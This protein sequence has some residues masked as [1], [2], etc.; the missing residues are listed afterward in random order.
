M[1]LTR[2]RLLGQTTAIA[3]CLPGAVL[4][5]DAADPMLLGRIELEGTG[6]GPVAGQTNPATQA[7]SKT[8]TP[9]TEIPQ[10]VTVIGSERIA[11]Q[12]AAK[13]DEILG[14]TAGVAPQPY[15]YDSDTNWVVIRGFPASATGVFQDGLAH[16]SYG[17]GGFY[18][19][20]FTLERV[21]V[22]KGPAS[23]LYGGANPGGLLN[24]VSKMPTGTDDGMAELGVDE[25]G[26]VW[27]GA[28]Q[29]GV[30]AGGLRWRLVSKLART[31]GYG[32]FDDGVHGVIA[33]SLSFTL[34][35]GTDVTLMASYTHID[36]DHVG[37]AWLPYYGTVEDIG[38]GRIDRDFNSGEPALDWYRRDQLLLSSIV[39]H[40]FDN[41]LT[42]TNTSRLS[43]SDVDE[44]QVYGF[45]YAGYSPTP[46]DPDNTLA[47]IF[48]QHQTETLSFLNDTRVETVANF[49]G[50]EH[51]LLAGVDY[52]WF[53]MD[54]VQASVAWPDAATGISVTNPVYGAPQPDPT[55]Y[56]DQRITQ[57]Q[58]GLYVQDQIRWGQGW[59][60]TLNGRFDVV[61]LEATGTPAYSST[62]HEF[63]WR[64]GIAREL[65]R[66]VTPYLSYATFFNPQIGTSSV[67]ALYPETGQQVEAGVKW[68]PE[69]MNALFTLAAFEIRRE[70]VV[71]GPFN[72][73]TQLG[74]VRSRGVEL[75][76]QAE[77][78][79]RLRLLGQVTAMDVEITED[80][81]T[82]IVGN[83][84]YA[85]I[86]RQ[87][88]LQ[89]AYDLPQVEGLTV[90]GGIRYLGRSWADN[91]NTLRVPDATLF[92]AGASYDFGEGWN[93]NLAIANL[94]DELYVASCETALSCFYGEGRRASLVLRKR[95]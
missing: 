86:E 22:L 91:E 45:G 75:E 10:S 5:Q 13:I 77:L 95:W 64:A 15:G 14:Y 65:A 90:T 66:G 34:D 33:P 63:S 85:T 37:G 76:A 50:T 52:R 56:I 35:G 61:D 1:K 53:R 54:Q 72:A 55:P 60:A 6:T 49:G 88:A 29:N 20:P 46:T 24:Y 16:Y 57:Q 80:A 11:A 9:L 93:M 40:Q 31:D 44:S 39:R 2:A 3:L 83:T 25:N 42:L 23:V 70:G 28:D 84:P 36:E 30:T 4:A 41:G 48:F 73:E 12:N 62:D 43:W 74:E 81:D 19:D 87:A 59:I 51:R 21:E 27:A 67:G 94:T 78:T 69:G 7:G 89:L 79:D 92:D 26:R 8:A 17:F 38:F 68:A 32:A 47:R 71:T 18:I 82:A 58:L